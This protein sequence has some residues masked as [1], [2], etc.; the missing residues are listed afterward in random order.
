METDKVFK[1]L[2]GHSDCILISDVNGKILY[3][4]DYNDEINMV[5]YENAIG[6][7]VFEL[8]PFLKREDFTLF[9]A[10]DTKSIIVNELQQF[11]VNG[12]PKRSLNSAYPLINETGVIGGFV[13]SVE[14][15]TKSSKKKR[16]PFSAKYNFDDILTQNI[17]FR[18]SFTKLK[19]LAKGDANILIYGET[20]TGKELIAHT[21]HANSPRKNY[22]FIIQNCAAIPSNLME[23]ILFGSSKGSFTGAVDKAGL[24]EVAKGGTLFLD[25]INSMSLELQSKL[26]RAIESRAVRRVGESYE[27]ETDVRIVTSTNELLDKKVERNEFRKDLFYRLNVASFSIPPL[28]ERIDD[29]PLLCDTYIKY[30][31][32]ML[33]HKVSGISDEVFELFSNYPWE[34]NV[35]ELKNVV[36]YACTIKP[37]GIISLSDLPDYLMLKKNNKI[38]IPSHATMISPSPVHG[39]YIK[40]GANLSNQLDLLECDIIKHTYERNRYS[41]TRTASE[42]AISRQTL[43]NKLKKYNL[44]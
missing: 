15:N 13:M 44:L 33:N 39:S 1:E 18:E 20:G 35:R 40:P 24:F 34:G 43:Y 37:A 3:Y 4:E 2:F 36:E 21:I 5:R 16:I 7:S 12:S 29:I 28:R 11:E 8:Y 32:A 17:A 30:N 41:I 6:R 14:L 10:M 26:L 19:M 31:N 38:T 9:R 23:S 25:E 22:P 42:L 27:I